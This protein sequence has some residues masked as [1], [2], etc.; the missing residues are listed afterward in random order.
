MKKKKMN[1][2]LNKTEISNLSTIKAGNNTSNA[3]GCVHTVSRNFLDLCC[4]IFGTDECPDTKLSG[5]HGNT[6]SASLGCTK[7]THCLCG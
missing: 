6:G 1:L 5:C 4:P 3:V 2:S 7:Q